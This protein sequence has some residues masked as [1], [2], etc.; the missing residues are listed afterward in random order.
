MDQPLSMNRWSSSP[1]T[2]DARAPAAVAQ[3]TRRGDQ[4]LAEVI[5]PDAIDHYRAVVD[6]PYCL[7]SSQALCGVRW[8]ASIGGSESFRRQERSEIRGTS[9]GGRP[10]RAG[11]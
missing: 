10:L 5:L 11:R 1:V 6:C 9:S 8:M 7:P 3:I 2:P 4:T